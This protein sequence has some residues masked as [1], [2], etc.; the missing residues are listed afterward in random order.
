MFLFQ[1]VLISDN[2]C[3]NNPCQNGGTCQP[4]GNS[5]ICTCPRFY[6]GVNCQICKL[7]Q[8]NIKDNFLNFLFKKIT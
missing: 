3:A 4:D 1:C 7:S 2:P 8:K 6:S 5:Y